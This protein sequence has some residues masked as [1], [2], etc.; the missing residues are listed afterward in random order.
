MCS[1]DLDAVVPDDLQVFATTAHLF[2]RLTDLW[3]ESDETRSLE[4]DHLLAEEG[5]P[6]G[7]CSAID[8]VAFGH[9]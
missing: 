2:D 5:G 1:S 3:S 6:Q 7:D 9:D 4:V 8:R